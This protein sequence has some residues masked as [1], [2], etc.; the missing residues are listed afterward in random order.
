MMKIVVMAKRN[1]KGGKLSITVKDTK[2]ML[3]FIKKD[4]FIIYTQYIPNERRHY[5]CCKKEDGVR[6]KGGF[7]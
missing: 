1:H 2:M 7:H 4:T 5:K 3:F 6:E